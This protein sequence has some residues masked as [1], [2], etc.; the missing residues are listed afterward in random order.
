MSEWILF[1]ITGLVGGFASGAVLDVVRHR[2]RR[3]PVLERGAGM[4]TAELLLAISRGREHYAQSAP[5]ATRETLMTESNAFRS[6]ARIARGDRSLVWALMPT[7]LLTDDMQ[8]TPDG[9]A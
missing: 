7:H 3:A 9:D 6:A 2:R 5:E 1:A 8:R 4:P